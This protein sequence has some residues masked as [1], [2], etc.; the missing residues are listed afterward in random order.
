MTAPDLFDFS[1]LLQD[2]LTLFLVAV[3]GV[4]LHLVFLIVN[5]IAVW[6]LSIT[7]P[8]RKSVHILTSQ[9][10]LPVAITIISF[11]PASLGSPGLLTIPCLIGQISQLFID[12]FLVSSN[13]FERPFLFF[14]PVPDDDTLPPPCCCWR[15][16]QFPAVEYNELVSIVES[17]ELSLIKRE[18]SS[19]TRDQE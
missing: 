19:P 18:S 17:E 13:K 5:G 1:A 14:G 11:L 16:R 15:K 2:A 10:T 6:A 12:A 9:K 4:S 8:E 3:T 7:T